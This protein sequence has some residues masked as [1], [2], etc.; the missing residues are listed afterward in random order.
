MSTM[1]N[2]RARIELWAIRTE[3]E[4]LWPFLSEEEKVK[5][6]KESSRRVGVI[7]KREIERLQREIERLQRETDGNMPKV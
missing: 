3:A 2:L 5:K 6:R 7:L 1:N 4:L